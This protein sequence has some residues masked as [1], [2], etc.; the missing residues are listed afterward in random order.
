[1]WP[2]ATAKRLCAPDIVGDTNIAKQL[3]ENGRVTEVKC[4]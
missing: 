3:Q 1:M 4:L 2:A